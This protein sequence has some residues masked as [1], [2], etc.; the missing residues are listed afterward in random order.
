MLYNVPG[1]TGVSLTAET[2]ARLA[3][4][5]RIRWIKEATANLAF[6]TEIR[7]ACK[8]QGSE[9]EIYSGDDATFLPL[10]SVGAAGVVSVASNLFPAEMVAIQKNFE[11]GKLAAALELHQRFYPLFRDLFMESN[12]SPIKAALAYTGICGAGVRLPLVPMSEVNLPKLHESLVRCGI[13]RA[14]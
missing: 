5:P 13:T 6:T 14:N 11:Q 2:V 7:D 4:H 9:I 8:L 1:R 3:H 12:P 10:L